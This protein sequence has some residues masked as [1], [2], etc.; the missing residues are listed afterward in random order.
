MKHN[1][2]V[3]VDLLNEAA[4]K[5]GYA[6]EG[7]QWRAHYEVKDFEGDMEELY[8]TIRPFYENLQVMLSRWR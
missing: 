5:N 6:D 7:D 3:M 2:T 8:Q 4:R 1:Y